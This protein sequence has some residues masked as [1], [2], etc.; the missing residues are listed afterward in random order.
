MLQVIIHADERAADVGLLVQVCETE[1]SEGGGVVEDRGLILR[2]EAGG[3][4]IACLGVEAMDAV[5][6]GWDGCWWGRGGGG[7]VRGGQCEEGC[8]CQTCGEKRLG[9]TY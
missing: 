9:G 8:A 4:G 7:D 5:D 6:G 2:R 1:A 3:E